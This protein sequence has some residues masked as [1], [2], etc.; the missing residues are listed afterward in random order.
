[1]PPYHRLPSAKRSVASS[2]PASSAAMVSAAM[3]SAALFASALLLPSVGQAQAP[4]SL[5]PA[6]ALDSRP[7]AI[8]A[9]TRAEGAPA[10][11]KA[12]AQ[13][14]WSAAAALL[15][16]LPEGSRTAW[17][18]LHLARAKEKRGELVE[19]FSAYERA[20]EVAAESPN[21]PGMKDA[22]RQAKAESASLGGRIPWAEIRL[23][24]SAPLGALVFIDQQWLE[25]SRL[26]SPYPVNA[27]WHTFLLE[28]NG[29][30]LAA[31]R[32]YFD[33]GQSRLVP[34]NGFEALARG[35]AGIASSGKSPS[36]PSSPPASPRATALPLA[37]TTAAATGGPS[38]EAAVP[39]P[40]HSLVWRPSDSRA[41]D[42]RPTDGLLTSAY[43]SIG[44][45]A[46]G[47]LV[48]SGFAIA[49]L[50]AGNSESND[51]PVPCWQNTCG[52]PSSSSTG[53]DHG[54]RRMAAIAGTSYAVGLVGLATGGILWL[55]HRDSRE[56]PGIK[57]ANVTLEPGLEAERATLTGTF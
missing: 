9:A 17:H 12:Y 4:A 32:V 6:P 56:K 53:N 23:A 38:R 40:H 52:S 31:R 27:G 16:T 29:E 33:E 30:V 7:A 44:V 22:Q 36:S 20:Q 35:G 15:E 18:W 25:P 5:S 14:Q 10:W 55:V 51:P 28:S 2:G 26:R 39:A 34:L 3:V 11:L 54:R 13:G 57:V 45:G 8:P 37:T 41:L 49:A 19:A 50:S 48:G 47:T 43:V 24:E 1:M 21:A 46:I 42:A